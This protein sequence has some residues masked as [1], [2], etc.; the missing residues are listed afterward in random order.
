MSKAEIIDAASEEH[1]PLFGLF[2]PDALHPNL[3][4]RSCYHMPEQSE[5][6][7]ANGESGCFDANYANQEVSVGFGW[8]EVGG[9][10]FSAAPFAIS[11]LAMCLACWRAKKSGANKWPSDLKDTEMGSA[12]STT[13]AIKAGRKNAKKEQHR[14]GAKILSM[15]EDDDDDDND[16]SIIT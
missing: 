4:E 6:F 11:V 9:V 3:T 5:C 12:N 15:D 2:P 8:T 10:L 7:S 1:G 13:Q 16:N 14:K